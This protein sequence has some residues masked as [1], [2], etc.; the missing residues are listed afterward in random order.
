MYPLLCILLLELVFLYTSCS[1][2]YL[3]VSVPTALY[4]AVGVGILGAAAVYLYSGLSTQALDVISTSEYI[5]SFIDGLSS[6]FSI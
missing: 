4:I 5:F 2:V 6:I 3:G 1:S